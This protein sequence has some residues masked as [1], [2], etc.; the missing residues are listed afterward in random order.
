MMKSHIL[1]C[2]NY[3]INKKWSISGYVLVTYI[4]LYTHPDTIYMIE[5]I[6]S[7]KKCDQIPWHKKGTEHYSSIE[8]L[9][10]LRHWSIL[11]L[12]G[13]VFG[14]SHINYLTVRTRILLVFSRCAC[15]LQFV[16]HPYP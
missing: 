5:K 1:H 7:I 14:S 9:M 4:E 10:S 13:F 15:Q 6:L 3:L 8:Q 16:S 2:S 12:G 11:N